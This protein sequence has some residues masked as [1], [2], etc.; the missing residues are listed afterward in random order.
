M[1]GI[2]VSQGFLVKVID[3][4]SQSLAPVHQALGEALPE[5][6]HLNGDKTGHKD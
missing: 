3:R 6:Q 5:Q 1:L 2:S 4:A